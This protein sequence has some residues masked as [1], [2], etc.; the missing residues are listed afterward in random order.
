M[1][2]RK[3]LIGALSALMLLSAGCANEKDQEE[4]KPKPSPTHT[5]EDKKNKKEDVQQEE[6]AG[7]EFIV[8][9]EPQTVEHIHGVGYPGNDQGLYIASHH[10]IKMFKDGLWYETQTEN[11]DYMGFQAVKDGFIASGHPEEGSSLKNP[12]GLVK[13]NDFGQTLD[14][15]AF[16]GESDF[17]FMA[18]SFQD[19]VLYVINEHEN[20][21]LD[22][23]VFT[24]TDNGENWE[25]VP[26]K[27]LNTNTLGMIAVHPDKGETFAMATKEGVFVSTDAGK[28]INKNGDYEM[29]TA[30]AFSKESLF[31]SP[32]E[33]KKLKLVRLD[34]GKEAAELPIPTLAVDNPIIYIAADYKQD[35][36]IAFITIQNDLYESTDGGE[37]WKQI[38]SKGVIK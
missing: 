3:M 23:G 9:A 26:L 12:L 34:L 33:Q 2:N 25:A 1:I 36:R 30:A 6:N 32:I 22:T 7:A 5:N 37:T 13:S 10:G 21:K 14:K 15:L 4:A 31:I 29:V 35:G 19:E 28:T 11:H 24:S 17:H 38:L 27:G 16:Y 20:S 8:K 18:A